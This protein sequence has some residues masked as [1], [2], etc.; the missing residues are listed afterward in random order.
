V[1]ERS[2]ADLIKAAREAADSGRLEEAAALCKRLLEKCPT[3]ADAFCLLGLIHR[4]RGAPAE[5][6][7]QFQKALYLAP[8]HHESLVH[9]M[10]LAQ[11]R[12]DQKTAAN[13][14]R[15]AQQVTGAGG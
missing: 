8:Q 15:R 9:M 5:A 1:T 3:S 11:E 10:L 14:R 7:K 13:L 6:E 4:A 2:D 12:G